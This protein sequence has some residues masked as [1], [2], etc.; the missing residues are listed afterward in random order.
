MLSLSLEE[1][2]LCNSLKD[3]TFGEIHY[4]KKSS[5]FYQI[6]NNNLLTTWMFQ[7]KWKDAGTLSIILNS[8]E[9]KMTRYVELHS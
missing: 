3:Y 2:M 1:L 4:K 8:I 6:Q 9:I 5:K 7:W